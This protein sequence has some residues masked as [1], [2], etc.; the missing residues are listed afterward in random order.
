MVEKIDGTQVSARLFQ[1]LGVETHV[2]KKAGVQNAFGSAKNATF[3]KKLHFVPRLK[4][5]KTILSSRGP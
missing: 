5:R 4:T 3:W 1:L 2:L